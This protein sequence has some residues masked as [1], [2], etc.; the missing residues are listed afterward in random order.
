MALIK[1]KKKAETP[2]LS[3]AS[4]PDIVFML[5]FFFM[6]TTTMREVTLLVKLKKPQATEIQKLERKD[7]TTYIYVGAPK[8]AELGSEPRIQLA[9]Q[10]ASVGDVQQWVILQRESIN[11]AERTK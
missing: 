2:P 10:L 3:T 1:K 5:L 7:L 6:V 11:E 8:N 4:L 9:D